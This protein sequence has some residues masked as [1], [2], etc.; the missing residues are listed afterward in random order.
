MNGL[1]ENT[2]ARR[3]AT[4][5]EELQSGD[6]NFRNPETAQNPNEYEIASPLLTDI[7]TYQCRLESLIQ[8]GL[9]GCTNGILHEHCYGHRPNAT[10]IWGHHG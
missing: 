2:E 7:L 5:K 8:K 10:W 3:P 1:F 6:G 9:F 4:E